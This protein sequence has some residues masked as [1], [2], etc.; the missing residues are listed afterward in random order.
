M[1]VTPYDYTYDIKIPLNPLPIEAMQ[2][3]ALS[4]PKSEADAAYT[5]FF[6]EIYE[7]ETIYIVTDYKVMGLY[8]DM[9]ANRT[10]MGDAW[11]GGLR[12]GLPFPPKE[13]LRRTRETPMCADLNHNEMTVTFLQHYKPNSPICDWNV[14]G[15]ILRIS[16]LE[17]F[18]SWRDVV[19]TEPMAAKNICMDANFI[20]R[21]RSVAK[22][23]VND[24]SSACVSLYGHASVNGPFSVF[25]DTPHFYG[26]VMP[27]NTQPKD[28]PDWVK[29][30]IDS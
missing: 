6:M 30:Q 17:R 23:L 19:P 21:F 20:L 24:S 15:T 29:P 3:L 16:R 7:E 13:T 5:G 1:K 12:L 4:E 2:P 22:R 28:I 27:M 25:L 8:R 10:M 26:I 18:P 11:R 14:P 9:I